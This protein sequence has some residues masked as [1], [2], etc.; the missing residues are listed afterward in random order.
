MGWVMK[1][2]SMHGGLIDWGNTNERAYRC[3][4]N[5]IRQMKGQSN[6]H[7][8]CFKVTKV[9]RFWGGGRSERLEMSILQCLN[10][11]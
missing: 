9:L 2:G 10:F 7:C 8:F 5:E 3:V 1:S 6:E 11:L 4:M